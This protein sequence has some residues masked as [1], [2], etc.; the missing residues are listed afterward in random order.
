MLTKEVE[1]WKKKVYNLYAAEATLSSLAS[2]FI[3]GG[4]GG[5]SIEEGSIIDGG[6]TE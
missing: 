3:G 4:D 2:D 1:K 5:V 6:G